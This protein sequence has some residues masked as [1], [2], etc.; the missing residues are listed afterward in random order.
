MY[1]M[2]NHGKVHQFS[3]KLVK[4]IRCYQLLKVTPPAPKLPIRRTCTMPRVQVVVLRGADFIVVAFSHG[5][6]VFFVTLDTAGVK[7][8]PR[9]L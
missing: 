9:P 2:A 8:D 6:I 7:S 3:F 5:T 4:Q 1:I